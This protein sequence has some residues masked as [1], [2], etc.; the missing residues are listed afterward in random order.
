MT[1]VSLFYKRERKK[2]K[3]LPLVIFQKK[4]KKVLR[5]MSLFAIKILGCYQEPVHSSWNLEEGGEKCHGKLVE[6]S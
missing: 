2:K 5:K 6:W 1:F 4:R 3:Y